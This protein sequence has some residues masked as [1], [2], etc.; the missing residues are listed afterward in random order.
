MT[1]RQWRVA[2]GAVA[3][4]CSFLLVQP[5]VQ[6]IVPLAIFLGAL[7]VLVAFLRAPDEETPEA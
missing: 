6:D 5:Q 4:V 7:N 1:G 3:A 2:F